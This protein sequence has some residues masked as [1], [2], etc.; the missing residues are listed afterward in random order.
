ML[1]Q[2]YPPVLGGLE[3]HVKDLSEILVARGHQVAVVTMRQ[4]GWGKEMPENE[5]LNG[6]R[7]YRLRGTI[8][9][10]EKLLFI[11]E[12]RSYAPPFP[13]PELTLAI[14]RILK[15]ERPQIVHAHNWLSFSYLPLKR[16]SGAKLVV[17]LHEFGLVCGKWTYIHNNS[18]CSGP[19]MIKCWHC[20]AAYYGFMKG[21]VTLT[22]QSVMRQIQNRNV[23]MY[24]PVSRAVADGSLLSE[25]GLPYEVIPNFIPDD[26]AVSSTGSGNELEGLPGEPF[27]LFVGS[28]SR[29]KGMDVLLEAYRGLDTKVPLVLIGYELSDFPLDRLDLPD[30][31]HIYKNLPN[32]FVL[33]AWRRSMFGLVPSNWP[34]PSPTVVMEAM[35]MGKPVIASRVGGIPDILDESSGILVPP[36]DASALRT[37]MHTLLTN[38]GL[39]SQMGNTAK[40]N[41][42]S[43]QARNV[44]SR[45]EHVYEQLV[46]TP[47]SS[48][49]S[50]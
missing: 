45:I 25:S 43:F 6:V 5:E 40:Q 22:G 41:V 4:G 39:C 3:R 18:F 29:Q 34:E 1:S 16:W 7:I 12:R 36:G 48:G 27:M 14:R 33:E 20:L 35:S 49:S 38:P 2:F 31:I 24:L 30:N 23:D 46:A 10:A 28:F 42:T 21:S 8:S 44:V 32:P 47:S 15:I 13:D 17:T 26:L 9:R 50:S 37:A 19:Q 11:D